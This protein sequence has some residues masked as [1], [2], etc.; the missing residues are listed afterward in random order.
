MT[1]W[2]VE[3]GEYSNYHVV[4]VF[5]T[6]INAEEVA[7]VINRHAHT[8]DTATVTERPLDPF[9]DEWRQGL[10]PYTVLM[11]LDGTVV[12]CVQTDPDRVCDDRGICGGGFVATVWARDNQHAI[13]IVNEHRARA[14]AENPVARSE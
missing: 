2:L 4:G 6:R 13:K 8:Y 3:Q 11:R 12:Y 14:I 1:V 10:S 7:H 9:M 5:S